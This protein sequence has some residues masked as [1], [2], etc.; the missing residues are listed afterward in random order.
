MAENL[1]VNQQKYL[2]SNVNA[3]YLISAD[4]VFNGRISNVKSASV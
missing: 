2:F 1:N 4:C 3:T